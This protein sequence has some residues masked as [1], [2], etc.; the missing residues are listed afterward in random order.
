V[1][2]CVL[3]Y[4]IDGNLALV[5]KTAVEAVGMGSEDA[6]D[7]SGGILPLCR[8]IVK[9]VVVVEKVVPVLQMAFS[10]AFRARTGREVPVEEPDDPR[11]W[12]PSPKNHTVRRSSFQEEEEEEESLS[13]NICTVPRPVASEE[14]AARVVDDCKGVYSM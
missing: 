8:S 9:V 4:P 14:K 7:A 1:A 12:I 13:R 3:L 10:V 6:A 5:T 2:H 11:E